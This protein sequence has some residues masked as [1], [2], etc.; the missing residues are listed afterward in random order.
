MSTKYYPGIICPI[1][2]EP[3]EEDEA[4]IFDG[5]DW[6]HL[7]CEIESNDDESIWGY[8]ND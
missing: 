8:D 1:C 3:I 2:D 7:C 4:K 6:V 5:E